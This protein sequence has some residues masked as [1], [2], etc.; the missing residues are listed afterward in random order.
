MAIVYTRKVEQFCSLI[1]FCPEPMFQNFF[2]L[3]QLLVI[4]EHVQMSQ[5]THDSRESMHLFFAQIINFVHS[6]YA[7][8][9]LT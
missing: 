9:N 4:L 7:S 3:F 6:E 5:N 2:S 8:V 1:N